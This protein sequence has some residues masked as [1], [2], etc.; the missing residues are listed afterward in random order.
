M[1]NALDYDGG[2][3]LPTRILPA[4]LAVAEELGAS[5]RDALAAFVIGCEASF[6][7]FEPLEPSGKI[8]DVN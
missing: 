3:H 2:A 6:E 7:A 5:G 1:A 8:V 4:V